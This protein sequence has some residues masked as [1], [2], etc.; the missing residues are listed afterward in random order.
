M[1]FPANMR[2]ALVVTDCEES[3]LKRLENVKFKTNLMTFD[4]ENLT[5]YNLTHCFQPEIRISQLLPA[6]IPFNRG[7]NTSTPRLS[8]KDMN[9]LPY[10]QI[11]KT[12]SA[13]DRD[14][15][16]ICSMKIGG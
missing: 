9:H 2:S 5:H 12:L 14:Q 13:Y 8:F 15:L 3:T 1:I 4:M 10:D 16:N 11:Y 6:F 7:L